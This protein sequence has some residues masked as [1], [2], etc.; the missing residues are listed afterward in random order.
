MTFIHGIYS[1]IPETNHISRAY[2]VTRI[3][4]LQYMAHA[5]LLLM[6]NVLYIYI[7]NF[8]SMCAVPVWLLSVIPSFRAVQVCCSGIYH[9]RIRSSFNQFTSLTT[10][11]TTSH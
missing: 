9:H 8:R 3:L 11:A 1:Y 10:D 4:C 7:S 2:N 5:M 6:L